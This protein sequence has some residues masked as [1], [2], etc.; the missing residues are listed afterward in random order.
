MKILASDFDGTFNY[1]GIDD[2]KR[3]AVSKWRSKE[4]YFSIVSGRSAE[5]LIDIVNKFSFECDYL[6][7]HNGAVIAKSNGEIISSTKC[8]GELALPLINLLF[9]NYCKW[10]YVGSNFSGKVYLDKNEAELNGGYTLKNAPS[11]PWFTQISVQCE[12]DIAAKSL[13]EKISIQ[14]GDKI[15]PLQNG[16]C[17][18]IVDVNINKAKGIYNLMENIGISYEDVIV[19]GDNVNDFEMIREF[20]SYAMENGVDIIK[21]VANYTTNGITELIEKELSNFG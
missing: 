17:I 4:N 19:V 20:R 5:N 8:C 13:T 14:F 10:V 7:G 3:T 1:N 6:I 16:K 2:V 21:K 9:E 18:D 15:N 11:I 12:N